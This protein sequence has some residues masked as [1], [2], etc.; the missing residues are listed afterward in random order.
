MD[1]LDTERIRIAA[2]LADAADDFEHE[3]QQDLWSTTRIAT[4]LASTA[5]QLHCL[6]RRTL[7]PTEPLDV[8]EA[9]V[10]AA[11]TTVKATHSARRF[12]ESLGNGG[13]L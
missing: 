11:N 4:G 5:R 9:Y 12:L 6:A 10:D 2:N 7:D 1:T 13:A 3:S 8:L